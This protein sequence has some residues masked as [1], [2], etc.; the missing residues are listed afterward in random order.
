MSADLLGFIQAVDIVKNPS[1]S[2]SLMA[3]PSALTKEVCLRLLD[4]APEYDDM[5]EGLQAEYIRLLDEWLAA[6]AAID[7]HYVFQV[8]LD[9]AI[10]DRLTTQL[11]LK[12]RSALTPYTALVS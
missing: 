5:P 4:L 12:A 9:R 8:E 2:S 1:S 3:M 6:A 7:K 11:S 10:Y